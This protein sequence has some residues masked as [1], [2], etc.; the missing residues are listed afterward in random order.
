MNAKTL[1]VG[2]AVISLLGYVAGSSGKGGLRSQL[3][4]AQNERALSDSL[5]VV[6]EDEAETISERLAVVQGSERE[7]RSIVEERVP[8]M[9]RRIRDLDGVE[10]ALIEARATIDS[11]K[12]TNVTATID[13]VIITDQGARR[14]LT[15][16]HSQPGISVEVIIS[17]IMD[18]ISTPTASI[19]AVVDPMD[20]TIG[21]FELPTGEVGVDVVTPPWVK[22]GQLITNVT[23]PEPSWWERHDFK[24]G[25]GLGLLAVLLL[26]G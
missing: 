14:E 7:L 20:L 4:A 12:V 3:R 2:I 9:A 23:L 18:T 1:M 8:N 22:L 25:V 24:I 10:S 11:M 13:T 15:Y 26:G 5:K 17:G 6:W 19:L 21:I 16:R